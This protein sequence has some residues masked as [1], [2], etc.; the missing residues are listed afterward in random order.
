MTTKLPLSRSVG[1][2]AAA[3]LA[4]I[5]SMPALAQPIAI[6]GATLAIGDGSEPVRGGTVVI[7]AGK[8]VAAGAG[9]AVPA[10]AKVID[11]A[12]PICPPRR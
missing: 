1:G 7:D 4:M 8:V 3:L 10:G 6:T 5:A 12:S 11:A 9:I 2:M